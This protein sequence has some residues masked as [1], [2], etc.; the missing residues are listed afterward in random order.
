MIKTIKITIYVILIILLILSY[1]FYTESGKKFSFNI[2]NFIVTQKIGLHS[3]VLELDLENYPYMKTELLI[4]KKY[5]LVIDG[6]YQNKLFD[7]KYTLNSTCI[8]TDVCKIKDDVEINGTI[9]GPRKALLIQ[10]EGNI[11]DG[12]VSYVATKH[13]HDF[14]NVHMVIS[15]INSS[16]LFKL[17]GQDA[18]FEGSANGYLNFDILSHE[19]RK[20]VIYYTVQDKNYHGVEVDLETQIHIKNEQHTFSMKVKTPTAKVNLLQGEYDKDKRKASAIYQIDVQNVTDLK[21]LLKVNYNGPFYATGKL[22]YDDKKLTMQGFSQSLGGMLDLILKDNKL[23]FYLS[24]TPASPLMEKF[25]VDPILDTNITGHG[26]YD[27]KQKSVTFDATLSTFTFR[28][29]KITQSLS[30]SS[31]IDLSKEIFDN[32][33]LHVNGVD[34]DIATTLTVKNKNNHLSFKNI[35]V[36]S[37]NNSVKS[38]IDLHMYKYYI[39]GDLY[40][41]IDKY[42]SSNDTYINFDGSMQK[43]YAVTLKGLVNKKWTSMDYSISSE[44]LPS[45]IC[46]IEDDVNVTGHVNGPFSRLTIEGQGKALNGHVKFEG[47]KADDTIK[48]VT[49]EMQDIHAQ[50]LSTLLGYPELPIGKVDLDAYFN[51]LSS[52]IQQGNIHYILRKSKL[53]D[54]PFT[55]DTRVNIDNKNEEFTANIDLAG[56]KINLTK[57]IANLDTKENEA[58]YTIDV[59]DLTPLKDLLGYEYQGSFYAAGKVKYDGN[60]SVHGLSKTFDGLTEFS[61]KNDFLDINLNNVSFKRIMKLSTYP[62][63]LDGAT[64]G[65]IKYD[66]KEENL[67]VKTKLKDAR[68]SYIEEMDTLYQKAGINLLKERF[69]NSTLDISYHKKNVLANLIM[70]SDISHLSL[71]NALIDTE[72]NSVNAYFAINMQG[73]EFT[74]K[75]Y[76]SIDNPKINLNMQKLIRHEMDRQLDS[77]V[78]EGNRKMM[79]SMPMGDVAKDVAS[80]MGGAFMGIFF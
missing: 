71:T 41:K 65:Y 28:D 46:T 5:K 7:L 29:S 77:I 62:P 52:D 31:E 49:I 55:L 43:Y 1:V 67:T 73:K 64:T 27:L 63:I 4:E 76:G 45:H 59:R 23:H 26:I 35:E 74:G 36:N 37:K 19:K 78:G 11:L 54:L 33:H 44:R 9:T 8:Q 2:L 6:Y 34:D 75:V 42:T 38:Y 58:L 66:F 32:N 72:I 80:G 48:N 51:I 25:D 22:Y 79:E 56:A 14:K 16:N 20:G 10:G 12:N 17:L 68:F 70:D 15:D 69:T 57:G 30:K 39:K 60:Y 13:R 47:L 53:F 18:I 3:K 50:K 61:Y 40:V 21:K 24:N